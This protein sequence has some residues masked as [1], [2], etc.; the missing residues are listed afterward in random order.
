ME[1]IETGSDG[2]NLIRRFLSQ[3]DCDLRCRLINRESQLTE[4]QD[5]HVSR[6]DKKDATPFVFVPSPPSTAVSQQRKNLDGS[7]GEAELAEEICDPILT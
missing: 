4:R 6:S 1:L 2:V 7:A 5:C 3:S